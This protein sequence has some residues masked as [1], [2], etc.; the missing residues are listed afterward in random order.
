[1][2][3]SQLQTQHPE[4]VGIALCFAAGAF[5]CISTSDLLPEVQFHRHDRVKLSLA[6]LLG[7]AIAAAIV[8]VETGGH[9]H[10]G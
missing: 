2:G 7:V 9:E 8:L 6:L 10:H 4:V 3:V 1:L 5:L